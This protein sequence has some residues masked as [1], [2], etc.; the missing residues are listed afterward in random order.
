[1]LVNGIL[2]NSIYIYIY[3]HSGVEKHDL[4]NVGVNYLL[5]QERAEIRVQYGPFFN[6]C[7]LLW[8][9]LHALHTR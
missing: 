3:N 6:R 9:G 4:F 5:I 8:R 7:V 2:F 1:M